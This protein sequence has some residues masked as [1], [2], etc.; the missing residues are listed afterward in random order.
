MSGYNIRLSS[1][2]TFDEE[3]E[4][5]IIQV[6]E[7]LN[8][9]HKTG[10]FLSNLIRVSLDCPE[11]LDQSNG[12]FTKGS[13][14]V[15]LEQYGLTYNRRALADK[16]TR[17]VSE[18]KKKVDEM[19]DMTLKLYTL[20]LMNKHLGLE[21]KTENTMIANF[22]VEKQLGDLK[23]LLG[24][25]LVDN[26]FASNKVKDTQKLAEESLEFILNTYSD[27]INEVKSSITPQRDTEETIKLITEVIN[28]QAGLTITSEPLEI[29]DKIEEVNIVGMQKSE[30]VAP[31]QE[32]VIQKSEK[33]QPVVEE[34]LQDEVI[35]FGT[36]GLS[37]LGNFF[38]I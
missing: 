1:M 9:M 10:N 33:T 14:L 4:A 25:N 18:M 32:Q 6:I 15:D 28:K 27:I 31:K 22:M 23:K 21:K 2:L 3:K 19:Y 8:S 7:K 29:T 5:D 11:I 30:Q 36:E 35:D 17:E 26:T 12:K 13:T 16:H 20:A 38:G 24:A 34:D 37:D